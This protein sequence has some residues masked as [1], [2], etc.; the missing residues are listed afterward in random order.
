M[1]NCFFDLERSLRKI[2]DTVFMFVHTLLSI[3]CHIW[4]K[5]LIPLNRDW[6]KSKHKRYYDVMSFVRRR[7]RVDLLRTCIISIRSYRGARTVPPT[8]V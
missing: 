3:L 2:T 1:K 4:E 7:V 6:D 8:V 5:V